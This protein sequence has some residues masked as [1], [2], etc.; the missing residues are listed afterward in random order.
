[1]GINISDEYT[2]SIFY[3]EDEFSRLLRNVDIYLNI[4]RRN[5]SEDSNLREK[6]EHLLVARLA[7]KLLASNGNL[8][9][10][11]VLTTHHWVIS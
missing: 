10:V 1:M 6:L 8:R 9:F 7:V 11:A 5:F 4:T 3:P 2:A